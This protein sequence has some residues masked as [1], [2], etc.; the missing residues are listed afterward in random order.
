[1]GMKNRTREDA[2]EYEGSWREV[3]R[4]EGSLV[5]LVSSSEELYKYAWVR[6]IVPV[7]MAAVQKGV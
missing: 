5:S 7:K 2:G 4:I 6:K 3:K 1:M